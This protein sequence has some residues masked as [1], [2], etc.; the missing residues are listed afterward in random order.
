VL[1]GTGAGLD[2]LAQT[3]RRGCAR[4]EAQQQPGGLSAGCH[5]AG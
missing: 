5:V 2:E 3:M 4:K 1:R